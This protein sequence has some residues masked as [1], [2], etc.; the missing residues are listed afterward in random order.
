ML[1]L[2]FVFGLVEVALR[3]GNQPAI[4]NRPFLEPAKPHSISRSTR[5]GVG[6]DQ[7]PVI[8]DT[9]VLGYQVV[10]EHLHV[11]ERGHEPL[12]YTGVASASAVK[13]GEDLRPH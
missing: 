2:A 11:R 9:A 5:S 10:H 13:G 4:T 3:L 7:R 8:L 12:R 6:P 1:E